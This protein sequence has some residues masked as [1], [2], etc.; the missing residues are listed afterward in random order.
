MCNVISRKGRI[1][2]FA[3]MDIENTANLNFK[4]LTTTNS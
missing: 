3:D 4:N 1:K 2:R